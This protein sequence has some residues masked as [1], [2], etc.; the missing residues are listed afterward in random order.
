MVPVSEMSRYFYCYELLRGLARL[1]KVTEDDGRM[2]AIAVE[3]KEG[4]EV[5][6]FRNSA[7]EFYTTTDEKINGIKS[8]G[9]QFLLMTCAQQMWSRLVTPGQDL[10]DSLCRSR[11]VRRL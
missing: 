5:L 11:G 6:P 9:E 3:C 2:L 8:S 1:S 10:C 4:R 7:L